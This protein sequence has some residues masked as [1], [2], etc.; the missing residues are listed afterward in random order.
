MDPQSRALLEAQDECTLIWSTRDGSPTG[1]IVS[2]FAGG[3][4]IWM[5]AL[6]H[7]KRSRAL[8]RD[9]RATLVITGKGS[10]LG[11]ARCVTL[12]GHV[13]L[14]RDGD[15][16]DWFFPRFARAVLPESPRGQAG[17]VQAMNN[18]ANLVLEFIPREFIPYDAHEQ[19]VAANRL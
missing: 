10:E 8:A 16:R 2:Y 1:T 17:M 6:S 3:G 19:M 18:G 14:H 13:D 11:H 4:S 7:S 15:T 9:P 12:R 5:T